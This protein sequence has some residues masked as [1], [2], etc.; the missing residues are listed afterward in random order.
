[1]G[2]SFD[3]TRPAWDLLEQRVEALTAAWDAQ[4]EPPLAP[5]LPSQPPSLRRLVLVELIKADLNLR[6][7][8]G[9]PIRKIEEYVSDFP[10]L[11][12]GGLPNADRVMEQGLILPCNHSIDDDGIVPEDLDRAC[13]ALE[14]KA[15]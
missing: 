6:K 13:R 3:D 10:E 12:D 1:M 4:P 8:R 2:L 5:L 9:Q 15:A 14:A 11:A 7:A